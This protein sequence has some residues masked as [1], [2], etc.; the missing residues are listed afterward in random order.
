[1]IT[2]VASG[3]VVAG[4]AAAGVLVSRNAHR[5]SALVRLLGPAP[6]MPASPVAFSQPSVVL[7]ADGTVIGRF[8]PEETHVPLAPGE[9]PD[10]VAAAVVA[11]EDERFWT[12]PGIDLPAVV[13]ALASNVAAGAVVQG[14]STITQQL[15]KNLFTD[16]GRT[17]ER[18]LEEVRL[19]LHLERRY[20]KKDILAAYLNTTFFGEGAVG[21]DA[22]ARTYL[23][24]EARQLTLGEAALLAGLIPAPTR[25]NPRNDPDAAEARRQLVLDRVEAA[26]L[27]GGE[28]VAR[29][30]AERPRVHPARPSV[31]GSPYFLDYV[32]RWLL[33]VQGLPADDLYAGGLTIETTLDPTL[34]EEAI[35]LVRRRLPDESGPTAAVAVLD[36]STGAVK[37][38]VGGRDWAAD[39][40]NLALGELGGGSGRQPGS[41][42]KA[43][44]LALAYE[45]GWGP[46]DWL[47]A[48]AEH[49]LEGGHI[50]QNYSRRGYG[51]MSLEDATQWSINTAY[52][53]LALTLGVDRVAE[54]GRDLGL[55]Q[56]PGPESVGPSLAIG[57]YEVSPLNMAVAYG[58]F[59]ADGVRRDARP[60]RRLVAPDGGVLRDWAASSSSERVVARSTARLVTSTLEGVITSG[61]GAAAAIGR[62]A[63]GKTGTSSNY[64]DAWFVGYTPQLV[65][66]VWVGFRDGNRPMHDVAGFEDVTGGSV[67]ARIWSDVMSAAHASVDVTTFPAPATP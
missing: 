54:L 42:F 2:L 38:L 58:T 64:A 53:H 43:I 27:A 45:L 12:H 15:A 29:A 13:R 44:V 18:K 19:T 9:I 8:Q 66:A 52:T 25:L 34:Q 30:R 39:Q 62:P 17:L 26:G 60:V 16:G 31:E 46:D 33:D 14:G 40:V 50:V 67:P 6:D 57:A 10:T 28:E 36:P 55:S 22:A 7:A 23:R 11:A 41:A 5:A 48:P 1:M 21:I 47:P 49:E 32:R 59:A 20:E 3:L 4:V 24:K 63:A 65:G 51:A 56:I 35:A 37:A 61:T